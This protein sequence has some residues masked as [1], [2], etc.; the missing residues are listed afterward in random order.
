MATFTPFSASFRAT[1]LPMPRELPV[2]N[3]H[4]PLSVIETPPSLDCPRRS[5]PN[6]ALRGAPELAAC[7]GQPDDRQNDPG[8]EQDGCHG[9]EL[10]EHDHTGDHGVP[11]ER[12]A[13]RPCRGDGPARDED[14]RSGERIPKGIHAMVDRT[15]RNPRVAGRDLV[16]AE[17]RND[18]C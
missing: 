7:P 2:I 10:Q 14:G 1:P 6:V 17:R 18:R 13:Q 16:P 5:S 4:F 12:W 9:E 15:Y 11:A 8:E 3:A